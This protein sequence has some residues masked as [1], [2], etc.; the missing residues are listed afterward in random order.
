MRA[1]NPV[2]EL[3]SQQWGCAWRL[4]DGLNSYPPRRIFLWAAGQFHQE[5]EGREG[6]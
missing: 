2:E 4:F 6:V 1:G 3:L 5:Q